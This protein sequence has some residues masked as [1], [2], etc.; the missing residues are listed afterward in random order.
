MQQ[1]EVADW[2]RETQENLSRFLCL[3]LR[4]R[5]HLVFNPPTLKQLKSSSLGARVSVMWSW[6]TEVP[7]LA[8]S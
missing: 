2:G 7:V 8:L 6:D 5:V 1:Q 3:G 4:T